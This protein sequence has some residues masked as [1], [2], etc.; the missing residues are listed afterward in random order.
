MIR[1]IVF[2]V[3]VVVAALGAVWLADRPG[4][5]AIT[6]L[7]LRIETSIMVAVV[8]LVALVALLIIVWSLLRWLMRTPRLASSAL[9]ARSRRRGFQAIS[10]GLIAIGSG[11]ARA[12][13]RFAA[14]A[15]RRAP[16]EP[17]TLLLTAQAAQLRGDRAAAETAFRSMAGHGETRLLGLRGLYIE[18][19]RHDDVATARRYAEE[20]VKTAPALPWAGQ[21]ALDF[22]C[23]EGDWDGALDIIE[24]H[25][26]SGLID[27]ST[28]RRQRAVLLTARAVAAE[29]RDRDRAKSLAVEATRLVP[30]LVPAAALA[31]RLLAEAGEPR[32]AG[33]ILEAAWRAGPH[34]DIADAYAHARLSNSARDRLKRVDYLARLAPGHVESALALARAAVD[35]RE[36]AQ[37]RSALTPFIT[38]PTQ[39]VAL[40]M[41]EIEET[42]GHQGPAREWL[43]R[44]LTA[45]RDPAWTADGIVSDHWMPVSP[46]TGKLDAFEWK[47]PVEEI[48]DER[49]LLPAHPPAPLAA[50]PE[51]ARDV[52]PPSAKTE[53]VAPSV[54]TGD[55]LSQPSAATAGARPPTPSSTAEPIIPLVH[56]PDDPGTAPEPEPEVET[57]TR[58]EG[59]R[60]L[61]R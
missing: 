49:R 37:A 46:V 19:R 2:L 18:A 15:Q 36:I 59:W 30:D 57:E 54:A 14:E 16:D 29:P 47:V 5:I 7:G 25:R 9:R 39:R 52:T 27:K 13:E 35:A 55:G 26:R 23:A 61:F 28:F 53:A 22:R 24:E 45:A 58:P 32:K 20:A 44:A 50:E 51:A 12:A 8:A 4:E 17:L 11:D 40:L 34:P 31:G 43:S 10:R 41:A 21:A 33:K 48:G 42:E 6:W 38:T 3:L 56:A 60:A 1:V